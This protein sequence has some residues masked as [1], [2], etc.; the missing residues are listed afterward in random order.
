MSQDDDIPR[1]AAEIS[2]K[3]PDLVE[4][5]LDRIRD[6]GSIREINRL[7]NCPTIATDRGKRNVGES[8]KLLL[9]AADV[10]F[11]YVD[12]EL[13]S[14]DMT[15]KMDELKSRGAKVIISWHDFRDT[16]S[17]QE[18]DKVMSAEKSAGADMCKIVTTALKPSDNLRVLEFLEDR[19]TSGGLVSFAMGELGKPSRVLCPIF[20]SEF[21][22]ASLTDSDATADGQLSIDQLR[23]TWQLLGIQ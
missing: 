1:L 17:L 9:A 16:P 6:A 7:K 15:S 22:F 18:L 3:H 5:R 11:D 12:L 2:A 13:A 23:S 19:A 21:T 14:T 4:F 10:G 8:A 20:G